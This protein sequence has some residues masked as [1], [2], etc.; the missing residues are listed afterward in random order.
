MTGWLPSLK[1]RA[2]SAE[3]TS[4]D[5]PEV[6]LEARRPANGNSSSMAATTRGLFQAWLDNSP[7]VLCLW[8]RRSTFIVKRIPTVMNI[9]APGLRLVD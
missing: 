4:S 7:T 8:P 6:H 1:R 3:F 9:T 2:L 5:C